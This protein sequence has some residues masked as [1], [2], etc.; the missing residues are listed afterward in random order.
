MRTHMLNCRRPSLAVFLTLLLF[1]NV[2]VSCAEPEVGDEKET[3]KRWMNYYKEVAHG[4]D[5]RLKEHP[6][7][8]LKASAEAVH[9]FVYVS[10]DT[11]PHGS[12]F[13][14][15]REGHPEAIAVVWSQLAGNGRRR[16]IHDLHSLS[17]GPLTARWKDKVLWTPK[18]GGL[19]FRPV[20]KAEAPAKSARLRLAQMRAMARE[21]KGYVT[22][23]NQE[24]KVPLRLLVQ[25]LYRYEASS[26]EI[27]DGA[28]FGFFDE[29]DPEV[30]VLLEA[31]TKGGTAAWS[32]AP[33]PVDGA[34]L[35]REYAEASVWDDPPRDFFDP[36]KAFYAPRVEELDAALK[37][38][39]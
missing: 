21:F 29:W 33:V 27:I 1:H 34:R 3:I 7:E 36:S 4:Y 22:P 38:R 23:E 39:G 24:K 15:T 14:W 37:T 18:T 2:V 13:V 10:H 9:S 17:S 6:D 11:K 25:P 32:F 28:I 12:C 16:V 30:L 31:R 26:D 19:E 8:K 35:T 20:P 5:I